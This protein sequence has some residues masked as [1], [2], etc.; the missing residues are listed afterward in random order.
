MKQTNISANAIVILGL[1]LAW[2]A[3][4]DYAFFCA[5]SAALA[6]LASINLVLQL[7]RSDTS[8]RKKGLLTG[9]SYAKRSGAPRTNKWQ[10]SKPMGLSSGRRAGWIW[11]GA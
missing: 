9:L 8:F 11:N 10:R 4:A 1:R 7:G 2:L 5:A 6:Q 3:A